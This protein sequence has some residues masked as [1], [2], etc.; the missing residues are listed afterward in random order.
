MDGE[1]GA[2]RAFHP[3]VRRWFTTRYGR[4][5]DVQ[6]RAW[7]IVASGRNVFIT[8]PTGTGKTYAAFLFALNQLITGSLPCGTTRVLYVSPLKAL[9]TDVGRNL[10]APLRE[11]AAFFAAEGSFFPGIEVATRSGDTPQAERRRMARRPP[12][13]LITTP[14]SLNLIVSSPRSREMLAGVSTVILDE[15]HAVVGSKR[16]THL[17]TAVDRLATLAGEFQRI[18]L[19]ATVKPLE[20]SAA[21]VAGYTA[22]RSGGEWIYERRG[23]EIV[24]SPQRK[25]ARLE[26][27]AVAGF[28]EERPDGETVWERMSQAL[29]AIIA[30]R[31]ST[32]VFVNSRQ[33]AERI[34]RLLNEGQRELIAYAHHGSLSRELRSVVEKRLKERDLKAIVA[35]SSLELGIDIGDLDE[36]LLVDAPPTISQTVQRLGRA[37]H[38]VGEVARGV[39]FASNGPNL[40]RGIVASKLAEEQSIEEVRPILCPL[41]VLAQVILSMTGVEPWRLSDLYGF[42]R[43]SYPYHG[44]SRRQFDL[45]VEMLEGRYADSRVREL[46]PRVSVDRDADT[47]RAREGAL[48]LLY[49]AGGTIPDRGYFGLHVQGSDA[50]IG[51]L[52]EEF[53]WE[54][55]VGD[56]FSLGTQRWRISAIDH[57]RVSVVPWS[58]PLN[59]APFWRAEGLNRDFFFSEQVGIALER[60]DARADVPGITEDIARGYRIDRESAERL[61]SFLR[62]QREA[63]GRGLPHRHRI[64]VEHTGARS[65]LHQ[66]IIHTMWGGRVNHPFSLALSALLRKAIGEHDLVAENDCIAITLAHDEGDRSSTTRWG[67][68][69]W[70]AEGSA[71]ETVTVN[72]GGG[73]DLPSLIR[74]VAKANIEELLR[75]ELEGSGFF[76]ARFREC[77]GRA[78]LLP[79]PRNG[80]RMPLWVTRLRAKRLLDRVRHYPDFPI[81]AETWRSCVR[82]EMDLATLE[83]LLLE[84]RSGAISIEE[85]FTAA[86]SPFAASATWLATGGFMYDDDAPGGARGSG[87]SLSG[88]LLSEMVFSRELRLSFDPELARRFQDKLQRTAP[89]YAPRS[90]R[91]LVDWLKERLAIPHSEWKALLAAM[92]RDWFLDPGR[93]AEE[94]EGRVRRIE[95][96]AVRERFRGEEPAATRGHLGEPTVGEALMVSADYAQRVE[97]AVAGDEEALEWLLPQWL[98]FYGP[99]SA[100]FVR[101]LFGAHGAP[102]DRILDALEEERV[103]VRD[104]LTEGATE[105]ELADAENL[106]RLLLFRRREH[107]ESFAARPL[108]ELPLF[109]ATWQGVGTEGGSEEELAS[110]LEGLFGYP[111][112]AQLWETEILPARLG[113]YRTQWLDRLLAESELEWFGCSGHR[114]AF[115]PASEAEL[116][117]SK[118]KTGEEVGAGKAAVPMQAARSMVDPPASGRGV[119]VGPGEESV[120]NEEPRAPADGA[121]HT[122]T[123]RRLFADPTARYSF[124]DLLARSGLSSERFTELI[125]EGIW[126]GELL[127]DSYEVLRRGIAVAFKA[128]PTLER[129]GARPSDRG[130]RA[131]GEGAS[132]RQ[133]GARTSGPVATGAAAALGMAM[134]GRPSRRESGRWRATRPLMGTWH[135]APPAAEHDLLDEEELAKDRARQLLDRY[136]ILFRELLVR[137]L[138]ALR[139]SALFRSLRLMELAGE[140]LSGFFFEGLPGLQFMSHAA[141]SQLRAGLSGDMLFWVNALDP[142]SLCGVDLPL[143]R[144]LPSRL[145]SNRVVYRGTSVAVVSRMGGRDLEIC[146]APDDPSLDSC[147]SL[148]LAP[149]SRDADPAKVIKVERINGEPVRSSPYRHALVAR[150]FREDFKAYSLWGR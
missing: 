150:G 134:R 96:G 139:W 64:L 102:F 131:P 2:L 47:I 71:P 68:N 36:V 37:G 69:G 83:A 114:I 13:I 65:G 44:L 125:W 32:L 141:A 120:A 62:R 9:N 126:S 18:A 12:E 20:Q 109:L 28:E 88:E 100:E 19:S 101:G 95:G 110:R 54:R 128:D 104:L 66:I 105:L 43:T 115:R 59:A 135:L 14:E 25:E 53:V 11:L 116:Y 149:L 133:G 119:A 46:S 98:Q 35:T 148:L 79:R 132:G 81:V 72:E 57:Q 124:W 24:R 3:L 122:E 86:P 82:D 31:A 76:G 78:L 63:T 30:E 97:R 77:S 103:I 29:S 147:L 107:A 117:A 129:Q 34:A 85:C 39:L 94:A 73:L 143:K 61:V 1:E 17:I 138:P 106:E 10:S 145:Q 142:I 48:Y 50:K 140:I 55:K 60:W 123:I 80:R 137:E 52:D 27:R 15:V 70:K 75:E 99:V 130:E 93:V 146:L 87:T 16:G 33:L 42:I 118:A 74:E 41:D 5:T 6:E 108:A 22:R 144:E 112:P 136:G 56:T 89:G 90:S 45:V 4:P 67:R 113:G 8:A 127:C 121:P 91:E 111:A 84:V 21:F 92:S 23:I 40:I 51:E 58:G 38:S 49:S 7:P 26:V